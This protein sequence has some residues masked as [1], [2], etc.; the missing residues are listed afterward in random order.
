MDNRDKQRKPIKTKSQKYKTSKPRTS[1]QACV[2]YTNYLSGS[3]GGALQRGV[4]RPG[5]VVS[6]AVQVLT[7]VLQALRGRVV[8]PRTVFQHA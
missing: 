2:V 1:L 3:T 5:V 8:T 4:G 6:P 7:D